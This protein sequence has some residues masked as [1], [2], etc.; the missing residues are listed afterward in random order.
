MINFKKVFLLI[1][2]A[3]GVNLSAYAADTAKAPANNIFTDP[4]K[5][6]MVSAKDPQF[7]ITLKSNPT[8]GYMWFL[9]K[10]DTNLVTVVSHQYQPPTSQLVGAGGKDVWTFKLNSIAFSAPHLLQL[11]M[12]YARPWAIEQGRKETVFNVVSN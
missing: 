12:V 8:T 4:N 1:L 9:E 6:I 5:T 10:Y 11:N 2:L 7:T 3:L